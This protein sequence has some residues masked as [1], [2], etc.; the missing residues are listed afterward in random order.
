M[1][2]NSDSPLCI[3]PFGHFGP[4]CHLR[5]DGCKSNSCGLNA[6]CH[7]TYDPSGDKP[8]VCECSKEFYGDRYQYE[9]VAISIDVNTT[10]SGSVSVVQF[11][12]LHTGNLVI[13]HQEV[14]LELPVIIRYNHGKPFIPNLSVLKVYESVSDPQYFILYFLHLMSFV[15]ITSTLHHCPTASSLLPKGNLA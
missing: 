1:I 10:S 3:C 5:N 11:Y 14:I 2:R 6:T 12:T 7:L 13:E 9:K 15:N 4:R 8:I